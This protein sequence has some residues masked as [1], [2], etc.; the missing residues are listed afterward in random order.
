[1]KQNLIQ[2]KS[3]AFAVQS[4]DLYKLLG[5]RNE[6]VLSKQFFRSA[7]SIGANVE[8]AIGAYSKKEFASKI[9]ISYKEARETLYWLRIIEAARF[10]DYDLQYLK[11]ESRQMI[12]I[13]SSILKSTRENL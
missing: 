4:I 2:E 10:V 13:L 5:S 8:E 6:F 1:M 9:G 12:S 11:E 3:F 7:T